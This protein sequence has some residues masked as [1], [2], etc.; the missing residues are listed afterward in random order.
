MVMLF[1]L[2]ISEVPQ[3][4]TVVH[5]P[6]II[7]GETSFQVTANAGSFIA[8]TVNNE[9]IGTAVGTGSPVTISIA[10]Q[11]PPN[12]IL[13]T[14]TK[15]NYYRYESFVDV[16]PPSG[17]YV[18][19]NDLT[20][21]DINGNGN[22]IMET[23][24]SIMA[25]IA[26]KNIGVEEGVNIT[27]TITTDDDYITI[28]DGTEDYGNISAG[29][30]S[31][32]PNGFAWDVA[33]NIPDLHDVMFNIETTDGT[34]I[35]TSTMSITGYAPSLAVGQITIDDVDQGNG[36]GSLDPG[37]TV[38][39]IVKTNNVG[40]Y[41]AVNTIGTFASTSPFVTVNNSEF[42]LGDIESGSMETATFNITISE[43]T[44]LAT[45]S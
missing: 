9:I 39:I 17:P 4:L 2:C 41:V 33:N 13:V 28:T 7:A 27:V 20:I 14:I 43:A 34:E 5:E 32:M 45:I 31:A 12:Q 11:M 29:S 22:G 6:G 1:P 24:E 18:I 42:N 44:P 25:T 15:Q 10:A 35:W 3:S 37:E 30:T 36:N 21:D 16:I 8:L 40:S 26:M 23:G 38:D 19:F